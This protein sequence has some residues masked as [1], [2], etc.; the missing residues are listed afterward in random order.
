M[1]ILHDKDVGTCVKMVLAGHAHCGG[2]C[3][4]A[5]GIH[6]CTF[7]SPLYSEPGVPDKG[8]FC[9][10]DVCDSEV[11]IVGFTNKLSEYQEADARG[12]VLINPGE[13]CER[14]LPLRY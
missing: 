8:A 1:S 10:V 3:T 5:H 2:F 14:V 13:L 11:R 4:D 12:H 7:E 6:H 9:R